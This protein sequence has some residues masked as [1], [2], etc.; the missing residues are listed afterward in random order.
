MQVEIMEPS[1]VQASW[2]W[3]GPLLAP[4]IALDPLKD[5]GDVLAL[6]E[7]GGMQALRVSGGADGIVVI[8]V[9]DEPQGRVLYLSYAAGSIEGGPK[10]RLHK[11]HRFERALIAEAR[12]MGCVEIQGGGRRWH[13]V[14][15]GWE[16][17]GGEGISLRKAV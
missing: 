15:Q 3:I 4:A 17:D 6:I 7:S 9:A 12:R 10:E 8:Q 16:P 5:E 1:E 11:M 14:L 13:K 2:H